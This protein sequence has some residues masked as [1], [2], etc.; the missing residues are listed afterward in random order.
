MLSFCSQLWTDLKRSPLIEILLFVQIVLTAYC[1]FNLLWSLSDYDVKNFQ[2][3]AIYGEKSIYT[4]GSKPDCPSSE[5]MRRFGHGWGNEGVDFSDYI[6]FYNKACELVNESDEVET[7]LFLSTPVYLK[8]EMLPGVEVSDNT[9]GYYSFYNLSSQNNQPDWKGDIYWQVNAYSVDKNYIDLYGLTLE[10][11][12]LFTDEEYEDF[13]F[14][15]I[16]VILGSA[17]KGIYSLGDTFKASIFPAEKM[18]TYEVIGFLTDKHVFFAPGSDSDSSDVYLFDTYM[19][20]PYVYKSYEEWLE[21]PYEQSNIEYRPPIPMMIGTYYLGSLGFSV[22]SRA[23]IVDKGNDEAF[24]NLINTALSE[25]GLDEY[26][27]PLIPLRRADQ[28]ADYVLENATVLAILVSVM[29]VFSMLCIAFA[30][31]NKTSANM[32]SYAIQTLL[33]ATGRN[34]MIIATA[35]TLLYCILGFV[36]GFFW[37]YSRIIRWN[38][39]QHP[40]TKIMIERGIV[41]SALFIAAACVITY[42]C[43]YIKMKKYSVAELIRGREVKKNSG[44]PLYGAITFITFILASTC[45]TFLTSYI[46]KTDHIDKYQNNYLESGSRYI[47]L[48]SLLMDDPPEVTLKYNFEEFDEYNIDLLV[49][50]YYDEDSGPKIRAWFSKNGFNDP[51][52]TEGRFFTE[53]EMSQPVDYVVVG[54]NVL[55]DFVKE[56]DGKRYFYFEGYNYEV[57]GVVGRDGHDTSMDDWVIFSMETIVF[58][59]G[60]TYMPAYVI[61]EFDQTVRAIIDSLKEMSDG[62]YRY[63]EG[64]FYPVINIGVEKS[65]MIYF[66]GLILISFIV[67]CIYYIDRILHIMNIKLFIGYSKIMILADTAGQFVSL[68]ALAYVIG[69]GIMLLLSRTVL[70]KIALFSAFSI[71]LPILSVSFGLLMLTALIFS[72]IAVYRAFRG[73]ARELKRG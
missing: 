22:Q 19:I 36:S 13:D 46:W 60:S 56:K 38:Y 25:T 16:P 24:K 66:I 8:N 3:Q 11:G 27:H 4:I 71:N 55:E 17:Y 1:L 69:N 52:I 64:Q 29:A 57:I 42:I 59:Y 50:Q 58:R 63:D 73:S 26:Y 9:I 30:A 34:S 37:M 70:S 2:I 72:L 51:E 21:W 43:G 47:V 31:V 49:R 33:G 62:R 40:A 41:L 15:H 67:F 39:E 6:A 53:E 61:A 48:M 12:R 32:R 20:I 18:M 65:V 10:S 7:A 28:T 23:F 5:M 45:I 14:D 44:A 68:S 35:E 54:K